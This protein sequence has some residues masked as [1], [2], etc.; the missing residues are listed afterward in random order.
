MLSKAE[1]N[2]SPDEIKELAKQL[3][4]KPNSDFM[5]DI[6]ELQRLIF[7]P[8]I[9]KRTINFIFDNTGSLQVKIDIIT[10]KDLSKA[11]MLKFLKDPLLL[12][13]NLVDYMTS[14]VYNKI[15]K[16]KNIESFK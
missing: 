11:R 14:Y 16:S 7:H 6:S 15:A 8:K 5:D 4:S 9:T 3:L 1:L 10:N 12:K 2:Y 13:Y